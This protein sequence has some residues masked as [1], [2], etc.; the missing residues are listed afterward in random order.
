MSSW[1][2]YR[3]EELAADKPNAIA[4]GPFG[5]RIR[6]ENFVENGV[7]IIRGINISEGRFFPHDFVFLTEEKADDLRS[8]NALKLE[9]FEKD[10][11]GG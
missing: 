3:V 2:E 1:V 11:R 10:G 8:A 9:H 4:M 5:S 7:P 6:T